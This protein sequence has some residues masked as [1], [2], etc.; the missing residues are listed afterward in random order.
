MNAVLEIGTKI[1]LNGLSGTFVIEAIQGRGSSCVVYRTEYKDKEGNTIEYL[2]KEYNPTLIPMVRDNDGILRPK[3]KD[4]F[5]KGLDAFTSGYRQQETIRQ[6]LGL[7]NSTAIINGCFPGNGTQYIVMPLFEG[8]TYEHVEDHS[9]AETLKTVKALTEVIEKYH[10]AGFLHLDLK[11]SNI[12]IVPETREYLFLFDFDS[13]VAKDRLPSV[14]SLSFS[15][16]WAA[17]EQKIPGMR[18]WI[19]EATDYYAIGEILFYKVMGKHSQDVDRRSFSKYTFPADSQLLHGVDDLIFRRLTDFFHHTLCCSVK[20]R[21]QTAEELLVALDDMI[22]LATNEHYLCSSCPSP[23]DFFIGREGELAE[24][25]DRLQRQHLLFLCGM[26]GIGKSELAKNYAVRYASSYD[27]VMFAVFSENWTTTITDDNSIIISNFGRTDQESAQEYFQRKIKKL[28]EL[29]N[30]RTLL[31]I[32]NL[33]QEF[34]QDEIKRWKE[35]QKLNCK[36]LITSRINNWDYQIQNVEKLKNRSDAEKLFCRWCPVFTSDETEWQAMQD[37]LDYLDYHTMAIEII[38]KQTTASGYTPEE[39]LDRLR[40]HGVVDCGK[41]RVKATKDD[42]IRKGR[43]FEHIQVLFA[44]ASLD[45]E[46][47]KILLCMSFIHPTGISR[48]QF[49]NWC[50]IES[51]D[52][53]NDLCSMS[54]LQLQEDKLTIHPLVAEVVQASI[55]IPMDSC[56]QFINAFGMY[57][58]QDLNEVPYR[59]KLIRKTLALWASRLIIRLGLSSPEIAD[60]FNYT[61]QILRQLCEKSDA[62]EY[63]KRNVEMLE[64]VYADHRA[65]L[66]NAYNNYAAALME[67]DNYE[68]SNRF[69]L[70]AL[71]ELDRITGN[72]EKHNSEYA[73]ILSNIASTYSSIGKIEMAELY[74]QKALN[75]MNWPASVGSVGTAIILRNIGKLY[76]DKGQYIL[77]HDYLKQALNTMKALNKECHSYTENIYQTLGH[78]Y[79]EMGKYTEAE[80]SLYSA[81]KI[82][83]VLYG[84]L[85]PHLASLYN[86]MGLL[87]AGEGKGT[88]ARHYYELSLEIFSHFF[89]KNH[90]RVMSVKNNLGTLCFQQ[91]DYI[92][93]EGIFKED[94][95]ASIEKYGKTSAKLITPYVNLSAVHRTLN[96]V[97][98]ARD[99]AAQALTLSQNVYGEKHIKTAACYNALGLCFKKIGDMDTAIEMYQKKLAILQSLSDGEDRRTSETYY[100]LGQAYAAKGE[101]QISVDCLNK[102]IHY[103]QEHQASE[104]T[105]LQQALRTQ[106]SNLVHLGLKQEAEQYQQYLDSLE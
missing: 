27:K 21:W 99:E 96:K 53:V 38:A 29:C 65:S 49:K 41:E 85:H 33:D 77:A 97:P 20:K 75:A 47:Q 98:L 68:E 103:W 4:L 24:I 22:K 83:K 52:D 35:I 91:G 57:L 92:S 42:E 28:Y 6:I 31:I 11:P 48:K 64:A 32:D 78:L 37:I 56:N 26:G 34:S 89:P 79:W 58:R 45:D 63:G 39:M 93:A 69:F 67:N 73:A 44:I 59:E 12:F 70:K 25:H 102:A 19:C 46:K 80:Q 1:Q 61:A 60:F 43:A 2:L 66:M 5:Q 17:P 76:L 95:D 86:L 51:L 30:P 74:Y 7:K 14:P 101:Y 87:F 50:S 8:E 23:K 72:G 104:V 88:E 82:D 10:D 94:F 84:D 62:V 100:Q 81:E 16:N 90:E 36:I 18:R 105:I 106:I 55:T 9:L 40:K 3:R 54:W 71:T 15:Q 13:V